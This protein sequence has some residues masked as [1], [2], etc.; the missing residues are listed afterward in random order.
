MPSNPKSLGD[1]MQGYVPGG[2]LA[3]GGLLAMC[4]GALRFTLSWVG[5]YFFACV[6]LYDFQLIPRVLNRWQ[7]KKLN[8]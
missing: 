3:L 6:L 7:N 4:L 8:Y 5:L 2:S 1:A